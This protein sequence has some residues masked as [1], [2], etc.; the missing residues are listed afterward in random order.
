MTADN[1][2]HTGVR[3]VEINI[4]TYAACD[5]VLIKY[6]H[7]ATSEDVLSATWVT[8]AGTFESLGYIQVRVEYPV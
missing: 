5:N 3:F 2:V 7:A 1:I 6:R 4:N 8:Y